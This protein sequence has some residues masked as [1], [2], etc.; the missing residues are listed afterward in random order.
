MT[1]W[2]AGH[3]LDNGRYTII[4]PIGK[5]GFCLTYLGQDKKGNYVVIKTI[6]EQE[7]TKNFLDKI[8]RDFVTEALNL[9]KYDLYPHVVKCVDFIPDNKQLITYGS[10]GNI[11][12]W[13]IETG[14]LL[15]TLKGHFKSVSKVAISK[16]GTIVSGSSDTD[17]R[18]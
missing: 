9:A 2:N 14:E 15:R 8:R 6:N 10:G 7:I 12:V 4:K 17:I 16:D 11:K 5:G 13:N 1:G 3:R 18:V